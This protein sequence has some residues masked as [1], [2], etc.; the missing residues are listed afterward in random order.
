MFVLYRTS[1]KGQYIKGFH[2]IV[3]KEGGGGGQL[4]K[5]GSPP[6]FDTL[7]RTLY[8]N[9]VNVTG[10]KQQ[11]VC[12]VQDNHH[13]PTYKVCVCACVHACV[14]TLLVHVNAEC[15]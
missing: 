11:G 5:G 2:S 7:A 14:H 10:S 15:D 1:Q 9:Y 8:I 3:A 6:P 4:K 13:P 12:I